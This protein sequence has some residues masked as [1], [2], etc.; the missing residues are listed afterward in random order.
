MWCRH[1]C[2]SN[3][4]NRKDRKGD[5][6][7]HL[8]E[9]GQEEGRSHHLEGQGQEEGQS[10]GPVRCVTLPSRGLELVLLLVDMMNL[11]DHLHLHPP[12]TSPLVSVDQ[13]PNSQ[14]Q[15]P[16]LD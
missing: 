16:R 12:M 15:V 2:H 4:L 14:N 9:R 6:S 8:E 7:H 11:T 10:S 1:C 13:N 3:R 5:R